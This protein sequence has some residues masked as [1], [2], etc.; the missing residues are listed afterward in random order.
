MSI[1]KCL[2]DPKDGPFLKV[3]GITDEHLVKYIVS[4]ANGASAEEAF[5]SLSKGRFATTH[6]ADYL[7]RI[8]EQFPIPT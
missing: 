5:A 8:V 7:R 6:D 3:H 1:F 2:E 4:R